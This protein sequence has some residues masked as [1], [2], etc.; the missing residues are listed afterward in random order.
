MPAL[1]EALAHGRD[2]RAIP[3]LVLNRG[4][5]QVP[6]GHAPARRELDTLPMPARHLIS[7]ST[8][9]TTTSTSASPW[10]CWRPPAA[11][12]S[13]ATSA[14]CGSSTRAPSARS[15]RRASS[16]SCEQIEAPNVFITDDIFWMNVQPR[17]GD[18]AGDPGGGN[19]EV[20]HRADPHRHH[21]QVPP[22]D[23]DVEGVRPLA[24]FLGLESVTDEGLKAVN[25]KNTAATTSAPSRSSR[26]S[27][28]ASLPTS[29]SIRPGTAT[30]SSACKR[31]DR[32]DGRLQQRLLRSSPR[33]PAPTSGRGRGA[34]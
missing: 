2:L 29:S 16:R 6:T 21:L 9:P 25:K 26:S 13:S 34:S 12:P 14:R 7:R 33:C 20:L 8:R 1:V 17:R 27:A 28:S 22:P 30:T 23:R 5:E 32:D 15:R 19:Q 3:G 11:V 4:G 24:I 18:G 31:V 10:R